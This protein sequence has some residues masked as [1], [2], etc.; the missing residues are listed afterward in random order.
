MKQ[1]K[2]LCAGMAVLLAFCMII[3]PA[4]AGAPTVA[5]DET[6]YGNLDYYGKISAVSVVKACDLN[7]NKSFTDYGR[8]EKVSNMSTLEQP[9]LAEDHVTWDLSSG[10]GRFYYECTPKGELALPWNFDISYKL[11]GVPKRAEELAGASGL[12]EITIHAIPS[13]AADGYYKNNMLL[14]CAMLADT[15]DIYSFNAPGSQMQT[16]GSKRAA[17][18]MATPGQ[19]I[20]F[21]YQIGSDHF[22]TIGAV[23]LMVPASLSQLDEV[24]NIREAQQTVEDAAKAV[25]DILDDTIDTLGKTRGDLH[26]VQNGLSELD[27]AR[28]TIHNNMD[29]V[30]SG[31]DALDEEVE[32]MRTLLQELSKAADDTD[33]DLG[34]LEENLDKVGGALFHIKKDFQDMKLSFDRIQKILEALNAGSM[35]EET[36][37]EKLSGESEKLKNTLNDIQN[38]GAVGTLSDGLLDLPGLLPDLPLPGMDGKLDELRAALSAVLAE[39]S[40]I[41]GSVSDISN[42]AG[43]LLN[44]MVQTSQTLS[45]LS[46]KLEDVTGSIKEVLRQCDPLLASAQDFATSIK[47]TLKGCRE[48]LNG[49]SSQTLEGLN[50]LL[51]E[52]ATGLDR[53]DRLQKNKDTITDTVKNEWDKLDEDLGLLDID[54]S[55]ERVSFTSP[56]NP[57]PASLQI[58]L[59]TQEITLDSMEKEADPEPASRDVGILERLKNIF[60]NIWNSIVEF[61]E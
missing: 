10:D 47:N 21:T 43:D 14:V 32:Q 55:A 19:D 2:F 23:L 29:T 25:D 24:K 15:A 52:A 7:G 60:V 49:G 45:D 13:A 9:R 5:T 16:L 35:S 11:N 38:T 6:V 30:E 31:S 3:Q 18:Y 59:R 40:E 4:A 26:T 34:S 22:E 56:K 54:T 39:L 12:V 61:F 33:L 57:E 28:E 51:G 53:L 58:V 37:S 42:N 17:V 46:G 27:R 1:N 48:T 44:K 41:A 36:A 8:Y 50:G 20:E